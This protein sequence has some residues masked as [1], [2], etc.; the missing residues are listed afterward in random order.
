MLAYDS[1]T[2]VPGD[3]DDFM[4]ESVTDA[5]GNYTIMYEGGD[6][7]PDVPFSN[8]YRPD[9]YVKLKV[10]SST[11]G[12]W[13]KIWQSGVHSNHVMRNPLDISAKVT[14]AGVEK[15]MI[16]F[17]PERFGFDFPNDFQVTLPPMERTRAHS[18]AGPRESGRG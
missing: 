18:A 11:S 16:A 10:R 17:A 1:D 5:S 15:K 14:L 9:I 2:A 6:W 8:S 3:H 13:V 4:G 7:D 12:E